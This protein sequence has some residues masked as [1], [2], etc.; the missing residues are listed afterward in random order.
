MAALAK[1]LLAQVAAA[2]QTSIERPLVPRL[3]LNWMIQRPLGRTEMLPLA[4]PNQ[5]LEYSWAL[6]PGLLWS[7]EERLTVMERG[8][9]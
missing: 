4:E 9:N 6:R 1:Q 5:Y 3:G 2:D 8:A 7:P